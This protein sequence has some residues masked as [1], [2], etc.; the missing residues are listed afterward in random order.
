MLYTFYEENLKNLTQ[1]VFG[2]FQLV[3]DVLEDHG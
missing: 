1:Y 2:V 3:A